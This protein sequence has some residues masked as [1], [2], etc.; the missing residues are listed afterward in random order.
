MCI[1]NLLLFMR[2]DGAV[3]VTWDL[4]DFTSQYRYGDDVGEVQTVHEPRIVNTL[5]A[6]CRVKPGSNL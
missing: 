4:N 3:L 1:L 2:I 5:A 6:G